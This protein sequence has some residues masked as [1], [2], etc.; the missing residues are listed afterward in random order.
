MDLTEEAT[1]A[2]AHLFSILLGSGVGEDLLDQCLR[3]LLNSFEMGLAV[4]TF[5]IEFIDVFGSAGTRG[6]PA[7]GRRH[8]QPSESPSHYSIP[9]KFV[10]SA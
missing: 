9:R 5:R 2:F 3:I 8:F 1:S 6:E 7:V 4:E 10:K